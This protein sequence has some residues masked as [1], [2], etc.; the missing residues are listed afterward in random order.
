MNSKNF[1]IGERSRRE[2]EEEE[3]VPEKE[4]CLRKDD[5]EACFQNAL[6]MSPEL[7]ALFVTSKRQSLIKK[8]DMKEAFITQ[9]RKHKLD[10]SR[11]KE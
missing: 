10:N 1:L 9:L 3:D 4:L 11:L 8:C 6:A 2:T 7:E 5:P